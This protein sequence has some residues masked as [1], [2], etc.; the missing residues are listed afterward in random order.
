MLSH[1]SSCRAEPNRLRP[2]VFTVL[3]A[4]FLMNLDRQVMVVLAPLIQIDFHLSLIA[5]TTV[6]GVTAWAYGLSQIPGSAVV[7]RFGPERTIGACVLGWSASLLLIP[8]AIGP[9]TLALLRAVLGIAQAP[10][11]LSSVMLL[12]RSVPIRQRSRASAALLGASYLGALCCGPIITTVATRCGWRTCFLTFGLVGT[13]LGLVLL[14]VHRA[15][16]PK[17]FQPIFPSGPKS[18]SFLETAGLLRVQ[19]LALTYFFFSG[20]QSFVYALL[21]LYLATERLTS[22]KSLGLLSSTPFIALWIAVILGGFLSDG[23]FKRQSSLLSSRISLSCMA[24][25]GC[26]ACFAAGIAAKTT[27]SLMLLTCTGMALVGL[28]QVTFW[29]VVQDALPYMGAYGT[30]WIQMLGAAGLGFAPV[31]TSRVVAHSRSWH[32]IPLVFLCAGL[33]GA[34]CLST[35]EWLR[36]REAVPSREEREGPFRRNRLSLLTG[37]VAGTQQDPYAEVEDIRIPNGGLSGNR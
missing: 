13:T 33:C 21:P 36:L 29:T 14:W 27:L 23:L 31:V 30:A 18:P 20:A 11:W 8:F 26:G 5:I 19:A 24:M 28:G 32:W 17:V 1:A 2:A 37:F 6:L 35:A 7:K 4:A 15:R 25:V 9:V 12:E 16:Q 10:D 22:F 34:A 3:P